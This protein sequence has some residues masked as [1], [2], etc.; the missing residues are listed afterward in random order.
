MFL[1]KNKIVSILVVM[2]FMLSCFSPA[3]LAGP[4]ND[5]TGHWAEAYIG[6]LVDQ[7]IISGYPD[8][9]FKPE[10]KITRAE[11]ASILVK[12]FELPIEGSKVFSDTADHWAKNSIAAA[13]SQGIINGYSENEFGP[14]DPITREQMA[15]MIVKAAQPNTAVSGKTFAD[16]DSISEWAREAVS[17]AT[18]NKIINGYP[19]NTF[20]PKGNTTRA[21]AAVVLSKSLQLKAGD[22]EEPTP[23]EEDYSFINKAGTYGPAAGSK[24]V[25]GNV[26]VQSP[27]VTLRNLTIQGDLII[28]EEVGDGDVN[29]NNVTVKGKTYVRGGGSDSIYINGGL[30]HEIIVEKTATGAVRIVAID[31]S[32]LKVV[33]S[34]KA[35]GEKIILE[36]SFKSVIIKAEDV[37][38]A[39]QG[40]TSID[41]FKV[42]SGL[43]DVN[44]ELSKD[45]VVNEINLNSKVT[46]KG[47]GTI[48]E[49]TGSKAKES[50][51][52]TA[53]DK[54]AAP[55]AGGGGGGGGGSP[56][57]V[58]V[59]AIS[60]DKEATT[61]PVGTSETLVVTF[62]PTN[63]TNKNVTWSSS[64]EGVAT[65]ADGVVTAVTE[66]TATITATSNNGKTATTTVT[67]VHEDTVAMIGTTQ[68]DSLRE[69]VNVANDSKAE[70]IMIADVTIAGG[71]GGYGVAGLV[72]N[73][74]IING[75]GNTLT[76]TGA[77]NT[78]NC[79][80]YTTGGTI[81][82][83]TVGGAFRGIFTAG[84]SEDIIIDNVVLDNVCYTFSSDGSNPDYSV[85]VTNSTLNGWTSFTSGY[86][87]VSFNDCIFGKGTGA[88]QYAYM[89]PYSDTAFSNCVFSEG[90]E[91]DARQTDDITLYN[92]TV[93]GVKLTQDNLTTLLGANA[94][95]AK[96]LT[97]EDDVYYYGTTLYGLTNE[98]TGTTLTVREGTTVIGAGAL[99]D[100][101]T[102][103]EVVLPDGLIT[104]EANAFKRCTNLKTINLPNSLTS[105]GDQAFQQC[106]GLTSVVI[107][108]NVTTI[109]YQAYYA[110][111]SVTEL[112]IPEGV[113]TIGIG[114]FRELAITEV[115]IPSTVESLGS[116]AFRDCKQL[117]T[118]YF[119]CEYAPEIT[120]NSSANGQVFR[121]MDGSGNVVI[122]ITKEDVYNDVTKEE[123]AFRGVYIDDSHHVSCV[124]TAQI[125]QGVLLTAP[126]T[127]E[128][129]SKAGLMNLDTVLADADLGEGKAATVNLAADIDL[130]GETWTPISRMWFT[131]NG[132][133]HT[134]SNLT[135]ESTRKAGLFG[136]AGAVTVNDLTL[137]NV[138]VTGSQAGA[139][140]GAGEGFTANNCFLKGT[141]TVNFTP[142]EET[143][144][145]IGAITGVLLNG[146][147]N[148]TIDGDATVTLNRGDM[149]TAEGCVYVDDLT[150][151]ITTN[152]GTVKVYGKVV[153]TGSSAYT[154]AE[155]T[156]ETQQ[157]VADT[158]EE[159]IEENTVEEIEDLNEQETEDDEEIVDEQVDTEEDIDN[160]LEG[161][162][163]AVDEEDAA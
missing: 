77:N 14:D 2:F 118:V 8:G 85:I 125:A 111:T 38:I 1:K 156:V 81:K 41:D 93:G 160:G 90:Y 7:G 91:L 72:L 161:E 73:G 6:N 42:E 34:D 17:A 44:I 51:F 11:F 148:V 68:Y 78:W 31:S 132:N 151:H 24:T 86:K 63:A 76:V 29:L 30:Y 110:C 26:T 98:F 99:Q 56:S 87:S 32:G 43:D 46:V 18:G 71:S 28:A 124:Y 84:C 47:D 58:E 23:V 59:S 128:I 52:A 45:T 123:Y 114:A 115:T 129:I 146:N 53:P 92:C 54:I 116:F 107:P 33:I 163:E 94:A 5:L 13:Y 105:I 75:N 88:Y 101:S 142:T 130:T 20:R 89:R 40:E 61:L 106:S 126:K 80:I 95:K 122:K 135:T 159:E 70:V 57:T 69:A 162:V 25:A 131:F 35:D 82:N 140:A 150:G 39:T 100:N 22:R 62:D 120:T 133:G 10:G 144:N 96:V 119:N 139:F 134:I 49:A 66:G 74:A 83:L 4:I 67:V 64:D 97:I 113:I 37:D 153:A 55:S 154:A 155:D 60:V 3:S 145:G 65:V 121:V 36:G 19:D 117:R 158:V 103:E 136:Y 79:A 48:K 104:I 15:V 127:Y 102:I 157:D 9:T 16:S 50:S 143:W 108:N 137:E 27:N 152:K 149:T 112:V 147:V 109:G 12:G 21:E 141:N 138:T